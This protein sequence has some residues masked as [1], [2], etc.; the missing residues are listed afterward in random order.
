MMKR[1]YQN[2][3]ALAV[4][5]LRGQWL[6]HNPEAALPAARS[7]LERSAVVAIGNEGKPAL[8]AANASGEVFDIDTEDG[9]FP[10][11]DR[12]VLIIPLHGVLTK[13]DNCIGCATQEVADILAA[14]RD[15]DSV[16]G[17]ILDIDS[18]G[19]SS[20][21]VMGMVGEIIR[22]RESGKPIIAHVDQCCSAAYWIASQ[23]DAIYAD[24]ILSEL[25]SIGAYV[26]LFDDRTNAQTGE[27]RIAIYAPQSTD[28]N[29]AYRDALEGDNQAM[30]TELSELVTVFQDAVKSG[31]PDLKTDADGVLS[32]AVFTA[33]K[34]IELGLANAIANLGACI[35]MA[36]AQIEE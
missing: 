36:F 27:R 16:G 4:E 32:G 23:C 18:P 9:A 8:R 6:L 31:R 15:D 29:K 24:N 22:T 10:S 17:F 25:G 3:R 33:K 12:K 11:Q 1:N 14:Y 20:N 5:I 35:E 26:E 28:K 2:N 19:G 30:E 21:A 34:A 13:Y 7:F